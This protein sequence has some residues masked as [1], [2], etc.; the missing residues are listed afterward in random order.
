MGEGERGCYRMDELRYGRD[1]V[2]EKTAPVGFVLDA[3]VYEVFI[4]EDGV[5]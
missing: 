4:S 2:R 3:K 5:T 1:F